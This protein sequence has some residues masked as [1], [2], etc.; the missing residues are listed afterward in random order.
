MEKQ[1][2]YTDSGPATGAPYTP[3]VRVGSFL[4]VSG[5]VP[6]DPA[7][8]LMIDGGFEDQARQCI[9]NLAGVL[10]QAGLGLDDVV[11]TTVFLT[12]MG[13]YSEFN[14]VYGPYFGAVKPA[15]S[16]VQVAGLPL[17]ALVEIEA[18]ALDPNV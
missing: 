13:N 15:R 6:I 17:G 16:C 10:K 18:I 11:K 3:A 5:Q 7:T 9:R 8:S 12:D 4:Y 14:R 2:I 1:P